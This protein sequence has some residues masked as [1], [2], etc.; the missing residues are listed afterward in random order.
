MHAVTSTLI[1]Q[2]Q[3]PSAGTL[4]RGIKDN[5]LQNREEVAVLFGDQ[6]QSVFRCVLFTAGSAGLRWQG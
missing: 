6:L 3:C 5:G 1:M 4:G 2:P